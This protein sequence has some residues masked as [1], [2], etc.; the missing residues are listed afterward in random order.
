[1]SGIAAWKID[2]VGVDGGERVTCW[3]DIGQGERA[4]V[5]ISARDY[6]CFSERLG[7]VA[8]LINGGIALAFVSLVGFVTGWYPVAPYGFAAMFVCAFILSIRLAHRPV[9]S[10]IV[11]LEIEDAPKDGGDE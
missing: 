9:P 2:G 3:A 6:Q 7:V 10:I 11:G 4:R 5:G 8:G 1:M